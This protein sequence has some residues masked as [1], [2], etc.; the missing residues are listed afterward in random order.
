MENEIKTWLTDIQVAIQEIG[1]FLPE[2]KDF[3]NFKEI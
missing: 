2:E 3:E 1:E